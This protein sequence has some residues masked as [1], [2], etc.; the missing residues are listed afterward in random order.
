[1][2]HHH[3]LAALSPACLLLLAPR[4]GG[5]G[6]RDAAAQ[7]APPGLSRCA[8]ATAPP[9]VRRALAAAGQQQQQQRQR[10]RGGGGSRS[11]SSSPELDQVAGSARCGAVRC[12]R[13]LLLLLPARTALEAG[14]PLQALA[15]ARRPLRPDR[16]V[17]QQPPSGTDPSAPRPPQ[18][19][20]F[21]LDAASPAEELLLTD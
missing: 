1:M 5:G 2:D 18:R 7:A 21:H 4:G 8:A 13:R 10:R 16:A 17:G 14:G 12:G 3:A 6:V 20:F 9:A 19:L 15:P 11:S